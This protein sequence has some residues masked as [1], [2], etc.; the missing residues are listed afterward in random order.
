MRWSWHCR[1]I[2]PVLV[3]PILNCFGLAIYR[4]LIG[5]RFPILMHGSTHLES[6]P[7]PPG[8]S[9]ADLGTQPMS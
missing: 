4:R 5:D 1:G 6:V 8:I 7:H 3:R 9:G 2:G